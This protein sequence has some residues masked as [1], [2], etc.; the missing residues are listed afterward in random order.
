MQFE[1][2]RDAEDAIYG[3][4]GYNFDGHRLRVSYMANTGMLTFL[5]LRFPSPCFLFHAGGTCTWWER[6]FFFC[7]PLQQLQSWWSLEA[8]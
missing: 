7:G 5:W 8:L 6:L 1:D 2:A 4:D 3:R